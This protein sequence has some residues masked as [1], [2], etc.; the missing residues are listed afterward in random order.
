MLDFKGEC[1]VFKK[2]IV[3]ENDALSDFTIRSHLV[4]I[5]SPLSPFLKKKQI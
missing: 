2:I 3:D 1:S 5:V 4:T